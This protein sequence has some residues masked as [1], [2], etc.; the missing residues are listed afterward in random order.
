[1]ISKMKMITVYII[2]LFFYSLG[3]CMMTK[4]MLGISPITSVA[5]VFTMITMA[6]LGTCMFVLNIILVALQVFWM[7][8]EFDKKQL[9]QIAVSLI[10]SIFI[11]TLMPWFSS[12]NPSIFLWKM[13]L[14]LG[15]CGVMAFGISLIVIADI[16]M[17]PG[18]GVAKT[19]AYKLK[20]EFGTA[21]VINDCT[22][23]TITV[24][25]SLLFL[26]RIEGVQIGTVLAA[27]F[28]GNIAKVYMKYLRRPL[29]KFMGIDAELYGIQGNES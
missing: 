9:L 13:A 21:K 28:L 12:V 14:L 15:S 2:G 26:R 4:A 1:M 6:S 11:D 18:D 7:G 3:V 8:K 20:K 29:E 24:L 19:I 17:L 5:Y 10:F 27:I 25:I 22:M 16:V 23:V